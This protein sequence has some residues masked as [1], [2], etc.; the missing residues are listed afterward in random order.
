M[1]TTSQTSEKKSV[2]ES[3]IFERR[4]DAVVLWL[5]TPGEVNTLRRETNADLR[6]ALDEIDADA[7]ISA[8]VIASAK[9]SGFLAGA[10]IE[11]LSA[12][13]IEDEARELSLRGQRTMDRIAKLRAPV[14]AAIHGPCLGG[15]LELA[16]ACRERVA[17][18]SRETRLAQPEV[19]LGLIPGAG[20]TQRLP[21]LVGLE[22]ALT[23]IL[24]G[25]R[26]TAKQALEAGL[27]DELLHPAILVEVALERARALANKGEPRR[28]HHS[29]EGLAERLRSLVRERNSL[30][31]WLM[32]RQARQRTRAATHGNIPAPARA[33]EVMRIG[34]EQGMEVGLRHEAEAFGE[35]V[36]SREARNLMALFQARAALGRE[37]GVEEQVSPREVEKVAVIGAGL[38][39]GGITYVSAAEAGVH[40]RLLD[41][42]REQTRAGVRSIR[43]ILDDRVAKGLIDH[44]ERD[45]VLARIH[46]TTQYTGLGRADLVIEAVTER[47]EIKQEILRK[48][49]AATHERTI[50]A[51][52]TSAIPIAKIAEAAR[53]PE[54]VVGMHYFS[55]VHKVPLLE[56]VRGASSSAEAVATA[57]A[58][59]KRQQRAVIVV[60]DG[61]GFYT[62]RVLGRY[63]IEAVTLLLEGAAIDTIDETL[64]NLGFPVGP[65]QLMDEAGL[66]VALDVAATLAKAFGERLTVPETLRVIT[67]DGRHGRKNERGF[68]LYQDGERVDHEVDESIYELLEIEPGPVDPER[69]TTRCLSAFVNEAAWC[70][71]E[72]ILRSARDGDVAAVLGL[73]FPAH[74]GGPFTW[75]DQFEGGCKGFVEDLEWLRSLLGER[76]MPAPILEELAGGGGYFR[77]LIGKK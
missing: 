59:G 47:L 5:D 72:G 13:E 70:Y 30:G 6:E 14:V 23:M 9:P 12:I 69:I 27:V 34:L 22:Q 63:L 17:S 15:G 28:E 57:V 48:V 40:V 52:N 31:R 2:G 35:L 46:P 36:C 1:T 77:G 41:L 20:G 50:F 73:G 11:M 26:L 51:S 19:Q 37:P 64:E 10:D 68:Y 33:I 62:S 25:R 3:L 74:L 43:E 55:P 32:Y 4:D 8:V 58:F 66:D 75:V 16:L 60:G 42:D 44:R 67:A 54:N 24:T 71:G 38:M 29:E 56:V 7:S 39:G 45:R 49:E 53:R 18:E 61:P 76:F 65:F 21:R